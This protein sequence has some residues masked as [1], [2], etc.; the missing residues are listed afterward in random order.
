[1]GAPQS[2]PKS[3]NSRL[4]ENC[5]SVVYELLETCHT[6]VTHSHY[7]S[8]GPALHCVPPTNLEAMQVLT[9]ILAQQ[10]LLTALGQSKHLI[11]HHGS[12]RHHHHRTPAL[13]SQG[14]AAA[15]PPPADIVG[16]AGHAGHTSHIQAAA[17]GADIA[18]NAGH[19]G[20]TSHIQAAARGRP[21]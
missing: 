17:R 21:S 8:F 10:Q 20:H 2:T 12:Q 7:P 13:L 6:N 5:K 16:D 14:A 3:F 1:M 15:Q 11:L 18:G 19:V 4:K 9:M